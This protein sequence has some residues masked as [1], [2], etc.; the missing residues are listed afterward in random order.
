M[1]QII[2]DLFEIRFDKISIEF[3]SISKQV[4]FKLNFKT[5]L[6][7]ELNLNSIVFYLIKIHK[8]GLFLNS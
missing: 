8:F 6:I 5:R 3:D 2:R 7:N 1:N 4:K